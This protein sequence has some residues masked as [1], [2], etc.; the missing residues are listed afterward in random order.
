MLGGFINSF[1]IEQFGW[2]A[3]FYIGGILPIIVAGV[4]V[5]ALPGSLRQV[6]A[7]RG[8]SD[9]LRILRS[10]YKIPINSSTRIVVSDEKLHGLSIKHLFSHGRALQTCLLWVPF[11]MAF[12][13]LIVVVLWTPT[14]LNQLDISPRETALV[15]A[16][17]GLGAAIGMGV[18]GRFIE[19]FGT[20]RTLVPAFVLGALATAGLGQWAADV[21]LASLFTFMVGLFVG[22]GSAGVVALAALIYPT[23][24]RSTGVG[25]AMSMGRIGQTVC[26]LIAGALLVR[27]WTESEIMLVVAAAPLISAVFVMMLAYTGSSSRTATALTVNEQYR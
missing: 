22:F 14:L 8:Q 27:A 16:F 18:A 10:M 9:V 3:I 1:V 2:E 11:F 17:N 12:G 4:L 5:L 6:L 25:M 21:S 7:F 19:K 26:P 20:I 15:V 24:I 13:N 23:A